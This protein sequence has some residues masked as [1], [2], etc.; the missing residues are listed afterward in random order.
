MWLERSVRY[1]VVLLCTGVGAGRLGAVVNED[2]SLRRYSL[3]P[4]VGDLNEVREIL[5]VQ[6]ARE[7]RRQKDGDTEL[8]KLW[9]VQLLNAGFLTDV[10]LIWHAKE[11]SCDAPCWIDVQLLCGV[12]LEETAAY[13]TVD[14]FPAA[15]AALEICVSVRHP[16]TLPTSQS[17]VTR[18]GTPSTTP[19]D[20]DGRISTGDGLRPEWPVARP[21][22]GR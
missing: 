22:R 19:T 8:M 2:A 4:V 5:A 15:A 3:S 11:S 10:L 17:R 16:A 20:L 9:C 6:A 18:G 12:G 21:H 1:R 13:L 14:G 7:R